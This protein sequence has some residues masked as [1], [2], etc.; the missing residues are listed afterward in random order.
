MARS[1]LTMAAG[2]AGAATT[3]GGAT[4]SEGIPTPAGLAEGVAPGMAAGMA[5]DA[6]RFMA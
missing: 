4:V 2:A 1:I 6:I 3:A 5:D